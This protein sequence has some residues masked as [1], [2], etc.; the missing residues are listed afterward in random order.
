M[1]I[2]PVLAGLAVFLFATP[3]LA[4]ADVRV[5]IQP[6]APEYVYDTTFYDIVVSNTGNKR[7]DNVQLVIDLPETNT[8]PTV[9]VMG[10]TSAI[11]PRCGWAGTQLVCNL[12]NLPR[13]AA[14]TVSFGIALP[15]ADEELAVTATASSS[16]SEDTLANNSDTD[17]APL[18]N[19]AVAVSA[20]EFAHNRHCTGQGLTS[21]F[22]CEL[23]L[24][25][26]SEH[27]IEFLAGGELG[28]VGEPGYTGSWSQ[29]TPTSLVFTYEEIGGG[30][31]AEF[32]GHGVNANC[33]EGITTFP[34]SQYV[35][36][37]EVCI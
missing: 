6:P 26:I 24:G 19:Y 5:Q 32:E 14:T 35:S 13:N 10:T 1:I 9:H 2:R 37:Y 3:V 36:P 12:G 16:S 25:S 22:E 18:L 34:G 11:D 21:F 31:V 20:G 15:Q 30:V 29:P 23:F 4:A 33:F 28:I 17:V 8:S 27:D 7:A